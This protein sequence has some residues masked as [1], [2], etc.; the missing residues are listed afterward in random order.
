MARFFNS[1]ICDFLP[2]L[3]VWNWERLSVF[4]FWGFGDEGLF[5]W[6]VSQDLLESSCRILACFLSFLHNVAVLELFKVRLTLTFE[7]SSLFCVCVCCL[8]SMSILCSDKTGTLTTNHM[9]I[10]DEI[11]AYQPG[12]DRHQLLRYCAMVCILFYSVIHFYWFIS[13]LLDCE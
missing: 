10:Q 8:D 12:V 1:K 4:R 5:E 11:K 13:K 3:S 2:S 7:T 6:I 9:E